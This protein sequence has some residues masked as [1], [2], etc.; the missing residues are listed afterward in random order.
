MGKN[1]VE[2]I[3]GDHLVSGELGDGQEIGIKIDQVLTQ[4]ATGTM[5]YLQFESMGKERIAAELAVVVIGGL[6]TSTLLT[7]IVIP[8]IYSLADGLINRKRVVATTGDVKCPDCGS[9][10]V[11]KTSKKGP[12]AGSRF[13]VCTRYPECK[14]KVPI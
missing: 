12:N 10:T 14:G 4:D 11:V 2:K 13:H 3:L 6:F 1:V 5:A 9:A 7:L 8:V